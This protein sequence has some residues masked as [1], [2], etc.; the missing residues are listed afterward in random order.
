MKGPCSKCLSLFSSENFSTII[1]DMERKF[2]YQIDEKDNGK[3]VRAFLEDRGYS[4]AVLV[5]LKKTPRSIL[6]NGS[7]F[8]V[9]NLLHTHDKL[10][11]FLCESEGSN[12]ILPI[13]L[14]LSIVYE[15]EDI[16]VVNK[17]ADMPIHPSLHNYDNTLANAVMYYFDAQGIPYTFRCVNRLDRDTTGLTVL[18]KHALSSAV[19]YRQMSHREIH[20]T[21]LAIVKGEVPESG[22]IDAPIARKEGSAIER[23]VDELR[24][25]HAVTHYTRIAVRDG[26]SLIA[27]QLET[28]RTH[29]IRVHMKHIGYPLIGDFLY[30]PDTSLI[31]RQ[32]LH[33]YRLE[34]SHPTTG[35]FCHFLAP[36]PADMERLF[37][38]AAT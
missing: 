11:V 17:P 31:K 16:L 26:L 21:Y 8:Y 5:Q 6:V 4:H 23:V 13:P 24:G 20:R 7:W 9:N 29:Q 19:L 28:G 10:E 33:A 1:M 38:D 36:L 15:D 2:E 12:G 18:P 3:S 30:Y 34:F 22:T 25:E 27:L 14:P 32:A 37:P 35:E